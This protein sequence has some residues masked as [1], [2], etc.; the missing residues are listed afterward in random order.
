MTMEY[1]L[2]KFLKARYV[3]SKFINQSYLHD[4]V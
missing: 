3:D 2:G 1:D 4:E